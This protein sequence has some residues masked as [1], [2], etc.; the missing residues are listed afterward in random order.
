MTP[1]VV[2]GFNRDV[3]SENTAVGPPYTGYA[4][5]LNPGENLCFYQ[6][7]LSGKTQGLPATGLFTSAVGDGTRADAASGRQRRSE[8]AP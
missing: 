2:T 8:L 7:G 6:S 3:V 1:V 4:L 5:E